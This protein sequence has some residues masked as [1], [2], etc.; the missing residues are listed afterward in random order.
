LPVIRAIK[1][2]SVATNP[3]R[4]SVLASERENVRGDFMAFGVSAIDFVII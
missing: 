2:S 3:R 4:E 1:A